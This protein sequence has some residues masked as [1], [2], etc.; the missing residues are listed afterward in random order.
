MTIDG[1]QINRPARPAAR[2][3]HIEP[4]RS[5]DQRSPNGGRPQHVAASGHSSIPAVD[6]ELCLEARGPVSLELG[7]SGLDVE[8]S[9]PYAHGASIGASVFGV[10]P[11]YAFLRINTQH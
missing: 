7:S 4:R 1:A 10:D 6:D 9:S 5:G 11:A 2:A 3:E 8:P